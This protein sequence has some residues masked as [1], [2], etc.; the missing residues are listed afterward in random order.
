MP[1]SLDYW[2][3][4]LRSKFEINKGRL[5]DLDVIKEARLDAE[6]MSFLSNHPSGP[7][8]GFDHHDRV[9][10]FTT[11]IGTVNNLRTEDIQACRYGA[12]LH[13]HLKEAGRGGKGYHNWSELRKLTKRLMEN[14]KIENR[15]IPQVIEIVEGHEIDDSS[16]RDEVDNNFYEADT[17]DITFLPRCF[18]VA[19]KVEERKKGTYDRVEKFLHDYLFY[20]INPSTPVTAVGRR[21]FDKGKIWSVSSLQKLEEKLGDSSVTQYFDFLGTRWK[22]N[23]DRAP[24]KVK[25]ML[26][27]YKEN[28]PHYEINLRNFL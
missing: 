16:K 19:Q 20:Q 10:T 22:N 14:A 12:M 27:A 15:Y 5:L 8:H 23:Q 13:D 2:L 25:E 6:V 7:G 28:L 4:D 3:G 21:M 9:R 18:D 24:P 26:T 17:V 11:L 1:D